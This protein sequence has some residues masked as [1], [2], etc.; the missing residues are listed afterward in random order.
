MPSN[1]DPDAPAANVPQNEDESGSQTV[2]EMFIEAI[3]VVGSTMRST[4]VEANRCVRSCVYPAKQRCI[5]LYDDLTSNFTAKGTRNV[6]SSDD[7]LRFG[8]DCGGSA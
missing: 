8:N 1:Q 5:Q 2:G 4:F 7:T 6:Y 3:T